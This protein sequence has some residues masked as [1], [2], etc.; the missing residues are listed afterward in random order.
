LNSKVNKENNPVKKNE[1]SDD[2]NDSIKKDDQ[3]MKELTKDLSKMEKEDDQNSNKLNKD[4][5][6]TEKESD[7]EKEI[8]LEK[9][10]ENKNK[11]INSESSQPIL[12]KRKLSISEGSKKKSKTDL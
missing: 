3:I 5:N 9:N 4:L 6:S 2:S 1:L 7:T 11:I 10:K 12:G 8:D